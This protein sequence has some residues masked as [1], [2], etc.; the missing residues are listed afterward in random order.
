[1]KLRQLKYVLEV[2]RQGN[3]I[4]AAADA[5][6]TSQPGLSKQI[7]LLEAELG[8]AVFER[9]KNK[10]IGLTDPGREVIEI[11]QR[12]MNDVRGL[13]A[14]REDYGLTEEGTLT[15]ATTHTYARYVI[16]AL[17]ER[18]VK[19]HRRVKVRLLQ[20]DP[21]QACRAVEVGEADVAVCSNAPHSVQNVVMLPSFP[22][23][24]TV[25]AKHGHPILVAK[26]LTLSEIARYQIIT[27]ESGQNDDCAVMR[28]FEKQGLKPDVLV[29]SVDADM[30]KKYVELGLGIA[31]LPR[32]AVD[33]LLDN[34]L[35]TREAG[36]LFEPGITT[37]GVR[38]RAYV[39]LFVFEF[40]HSLDPALSAEV[41]TAA[42]AGNEPISGGVESIV[43]DKPM[44]PVPRR[45]I[46]RR[47]KRGAGQHVA[48]SSPFFA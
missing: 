30:T 9:T 12:M 17:V 16:P 5:L 2:H 18:F 13:R 23:A 3:N 25:V 48:H 44:A 28:A 36:A 37:V 7:Q 26:E 27:S 1:M 34:A 31:V 15:I 19:K 10:V 43:L 11:A 35:G 22:I 38:K 41:V 8:F 24:W 6:H 21:A 4:S 46:R 20:R 39:R 40:I 42:I 32:I 47:S 14:I 45:D 29:S 33:P